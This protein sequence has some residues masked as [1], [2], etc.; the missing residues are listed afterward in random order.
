MEELCSVLET[1]GVVV[2]LEGAPGSGV[3]TV[4]GAVAT[5]MGESMPVRVLRLAGSL[6]TLHFFHMVG[7]TIGA[8]FPGD[9]SSVGETLA[10]LGEVL[11]LLDD[12]DRPDTASVVERLSAV[13]PRARF[14]AAGRWAPVPGP[15]FQLSPLPDNVI[16]VI[17]P[18]CAPSLLQGNPLLALLVQECRAP[19]SNPWA[20][21]QN[22]PRQVDILAACPAGVPG[23]APPG[24]PPQLLLST[25]AHFT[26]LRRAVA[27]SLA[28]LRTPS[29]R[30]IARSLHSRCTSILSLGTGAS[31]DSVPDPRVLPVLDHIGTHHPDPWE[32]ARATAALA[33]IRIAAGQAAAARVWRQA[34]ENRPSDGSGREQALLA[35]AEGDALL[36]DGETREALVA[37]EIAATQLRRARAAP[38]LASLHRRCGDLLTGRGLL[39]TALERYREAADLHRKLGD[40]LGLASALRGEAEVLLSQHNGVEAERLL[41][42]ASAIL[43]AMEDQGP[44]MACVLLARAR[45]EMERGELDKAETFLDEAAATVHNL[46]LLRANFLLMQAVLQLRRGNPQSA[47]PHLLKAAEIFSRMGQR[48]SAAYAVRLLGDTAALMGDPDLANSF[49]ERATREQVRAGDLL[50]LGRTLSHRRVL[51]QEMGDPE[52]AILLRRL[53]DEVRWVREA[54]D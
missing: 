16:A 27:E 44:V 13:A 22:I 51:E 10:E 12:A 48:D 34:A 35:W 26:V 33:R 3:S 28:N 46:P 49:Y 43:D 50:G 54:D 39:Q 52:T 23:S 21:L 7:W 25:D 17:C 37:W 29:P 4:L 5:R 42:L 19:P 1:P 41:I 53:A 15:N 11:L 30:A 9:Q 38:V 45:L 20:I 6:D 2:S 8:P 14:L 36:A 31:L 24:L 18:N 40:T 32:A 47:R